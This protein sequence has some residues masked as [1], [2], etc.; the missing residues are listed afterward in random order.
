[1]S[2]DASFRSQVKG[3]LLNTLGSSVLEA[4]HTAAQLIAKIASIE[5]PRK[6]W[7]ELIA[8]LLGN[9][10]QQDKPASLKQATLEAL[11]YVCEEISHNDLVQ[12]EVNS[13]LTA[14]VQGHLEDLISPTHIFFMSFFGSMFRQ[15]FVCQT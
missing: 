3:L 12:D 11:G 10:I 4:G 2:N 15:L 5:I 8:S 6:E 1:M 9:M 7:P 13:V 14:V